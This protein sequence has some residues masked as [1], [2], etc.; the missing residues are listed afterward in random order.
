[1]AYDVELVIPML[2]R[3]S[4]LSNRELLA[5]FSKIMEELKRRGVIRTFNNPVA[6]YCES[7]TAFALSLQLE[8][9]SHKGYD[10]V[11]SA[12]MKYQIKGRLIHDPH[13]LNQLSIIRNLQAREFD[14]L[15]AV[16]LDPNFSVMEAYKIP[17]T[18]VAK[19]SSYN[20][21]Q[22][23]NILRLKG[24]IVEDPGIEKIGNRLRVDLPARNG[25][26]SSRI[27]PS[28]GK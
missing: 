25:I 5:T 13:S 4:E 1:V 18:L 12:G 21:Y 15:I 23:G 19:Y 11:D 16:L 9:N 8:G 7:L 28:R 26:A 20:E 6:D 17:H 14:F 27:E 3:T 22:H 10:A 24:Q 2:P